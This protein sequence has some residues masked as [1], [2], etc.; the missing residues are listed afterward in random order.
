MWTLSHLINLCL[1]IVEIKILTLYTETWMPFICYG[2]GGTDLWT[3]AKHK[4]D[5]PI[6]SLTTENYRRHSRSSASYWCLV[7][8]R[9]W[10][11]TTKIT[12]GL[13]SLGPHTKQRGMHCSCCVLSCPLENLDSQISFLCQ[14][15][16]IKTGTLGTW[17]NVWY[18]GGKKEIFLKENHVDLLLTK[19]TEKFGNG[20]SK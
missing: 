11:V 2:G 3:L 10:W 8:S 19:A 9:H 15:L 4:L 16:Y 13:A 18:A 20:E 14:I 1:R 17:E 6:L 5:L 12:L 7:L